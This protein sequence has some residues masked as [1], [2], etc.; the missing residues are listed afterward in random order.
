NLPQP[1]PSYFLQTLP[2]PNRPQIVE[3]QEIPLSSED[4]Q[5][6]PAQWRPQQEQL[7]HQQTIQQLQLLLQQQQFQL[8]L[9]LNLHLHLQQQQQQQ[10]VGPS[11]IENTSFLSKL[12][13][14]TLL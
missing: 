14:M 1:Q 5:Q 2:R 4:Q 6:L 8:Q 10:R 13:Q 11:G 7:M 12:L 9:H 3:L